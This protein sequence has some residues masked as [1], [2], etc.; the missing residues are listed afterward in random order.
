SIEIDLHPMGPRPFLAILVILV[1][2]QYV[3]RRQCVSWHSGHTSQFLSVSGHSSSAPATKANRVAI[4]SESTNDLTAPTH[5]IPRGD[6]NRTTGLP[7]AIRSTP[8]RR[9]LTSRL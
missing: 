7:T 1:E 9:I 4:G 8:S 5:R 2:H 3:S 6:E